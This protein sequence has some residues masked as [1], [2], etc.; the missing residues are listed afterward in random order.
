MERKPANHHIETMTR[1]LLAAVVM[2]LTVGISWASAQTTNDGQATDQ[3]ADAVA[4]QIEEVA[5]ESPYRIVQV[6]DDIYRFTDNRHHSV[7]LVTDDG[8]LVTDPID[9]EAATWLKDQLDERFEV[10]VRYVVYS[11]SHPDHVYG[12]EVFAEPGVTFVAHRK[13]RADLER[14]RADTHLPDVT[15]EDETT[16]RLGDHAVRLTYHGPNNGRGSISMLF[17]RSDLLF[18]VDWVVLGRM[19]YKDLP[20]YDL[21]GMIESTREVLEMD[22]EVFVGGH[23]DIGGPKEVRRYL[24]YLEALY[25]GVVDGMHAGKSLDQLKQE[26]QL[27]E[28]SDLKMYEEW[29]EPNIEGAYEML[30]DDDYMLRRPEVPEPE[31][32]E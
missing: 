19:P 6:T 29:R 26:L 21:A 10:P 18:V 17:E 16:L 15:F 28:Y 22:F 13:A 12:G 2:A 8:I 1:Q 30:R 9:T 11:H 14:T 32:D 31:G 3:A 7:F 20:G 27:E 5:S 23:A 24:S 4:D 25:G